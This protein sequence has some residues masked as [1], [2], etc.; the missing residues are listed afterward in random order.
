MRSANASGRSCG[1]SGSKGMVGAGSRS[2]PGV[3]GSCGC[4]CGGS[5][6]GSGDGG[7][8][9]CTSGTPEATDRNGA[10]AASCL[11]QRPRFF[12]GEMVT[13]FDLTALVDYQRAQS[14]LSNGVIGG[15]GV[16]S[17]Y[18]LAIDLD[19]CAVLV[20]PG[21]AFDARG[22]ALIRSAP[23]P[24]TRPAAQDVGRP[25]EPCDP[26]VVPPPDETLYLAVVYDDCLDA[27]KPRYGG[28]CGPSPDAGC[29]FS[30]V[31]ERSR[32]VWV[33][34]SSVAA[35]YWTSGCLPDPCAERARQADPEPLPACE[36]PSLDRCT[37]DI[38]IHGGVGVERYG[39][40]LRHEWNLTRN[41]T[42]IQ[43]RSSGE[44]QDPCCGAGVGAVI[45]VIA[46]VA[47]PPCQGEA[48]VIL[49]EVSFTTDPANK[50]PSIR[51]LPL[52]RPVLSNAD[53]T[54]LVGYLLERALCPARGPSPDVIAVDPPAPQGLCADP[55]IGAKPDIERFA[56]ITAGDNV[57]A[58]R[59]VAEKLAYRAVMKGERSLSS[60]GVE[61]LVGLAREVG[62]NGLSRADENAL[63]ARY[64]D[65]AGRAAYEAAA[66]EMLASLD[67]PR[68]DEPR[69][70]K[71]KQYLT[72]QFSKL[73]GTQRT[74]GWKPFVELARKVYELAGV[75]LTAARL[76]E[77]AGSHPDASFEDESAQRSESLARQE[78]E[79]LKAQLAA[80]QEQLASTQAGKPAEGGDDTS[81]ISTALR[82]S[83]PARAPG[84]P[85]PALSS[86]SPATPAVPE[87]EVAPERTAP[88]ENEAKPGSQPP[89][90]SEE[91]IVGDERAPAAPH[92]RPKKRRS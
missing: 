20:G 42:L 91:A 6:G 40:A 87:S 34:P 7:D 18:S 39:H 21:I 48:L 24:L 4:G 82:A 33:N 51:V 28:P 59:A 41:A 67:I 22:R 44:N 26:C 74:I 47:S 27:P 64:R 60:L 1:C 61:D 36:E 19:A 83:P 78:L 69:R 76:R 12:P 66:V 14:L 43:N 38:G 57:D 88:E 75:E 35:S 81:R 10:S 54:Y 50:Q 71:A 85:T 73:R 8:D 68:L 37:P 84:P 23:T 30:R 46:G 5:G 49:A 80:V 3:G 13:D 90:S 70:I 55:C 62:G 15:W 32:L 77:L 52:R 86:P 53:L 29:D 16:Y 11:P 79:A 65:A 45:D 31:Q 89:P 56:E 2:R 9:A 58:R 72:D 17:G 25:R 63:R 92:G